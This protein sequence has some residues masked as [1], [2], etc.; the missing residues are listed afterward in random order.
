M[1]KLTIS[2]FTLRIISAVVLG[3]IFLLIPET[4]LKTIVII[5]GVLFIVPGLFA[6]IK[7]LFSNS[8]RRPDI[9]FLFAG[10]GS[11]LFGVAL[12]WQP[13]FFVAVLMY[14]LGVVLLLA[15]IEQL[16]TV[17]RARANTQ[18]PTFFYIIPVLLL[19]AGVIVVV[20]PES[21]A[22]FIMRLIGVMSIVYA[23]MEV[24]Y[25]V[26]FKR[27]EAAVKVVE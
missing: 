6:F 3:V 2:F 9:L 1:K 22:A 5:I 27:H 4:A 13:D 12:V 24:I 20:N 18:V 7:Y 16:V 11:L 23:I 10:L 21:F 17:I 25:H 15:G 8:E 14:I 19:V 26:K